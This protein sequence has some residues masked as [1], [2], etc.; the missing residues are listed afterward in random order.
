MSNNKF[1]NDYFYENYRLA[2]FYDELY[3]DI[4]DIPFWLRYINTNEDVLEIAC[5]TGRLT[6]PL[7]EKMQKGIIYA[8]DY[9]SEMLEKLNEKIAYSDH[10]DKIF[11]ILGDMRNFDLGKKF[12]T[13]I[14][15]ANSLNHIEKNEDLIK[16]FENF[17][18]HL[19]DDGKILFDV[20]NPKFEFLQ[21]DFN[22][23]YD[24]MVIKKGN[25]YFSMEE[26]N[27][28]EHKTQINSVS[29]FYNYC[30]ANGVKTYGHSEYR[31]DIKV[32]L[33]FPQEMDA[34]IKFLGL[35]IDGKFDN[36]NGDNFT[37]KTSEQIYIVSKADM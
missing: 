20:L 33:F 2:E 3:G 22:K 31:M 37:G 26:S 23:R 35:K 8:L 7:S 6:I 9:S 29:Y 14:I 13:I 15:S 5:G 12:K 17:K 4:S 27:R 21:R 16:V 36:F 19:D 30:D 25:L 10:K 32:R 24:F 11:P 1:K 18:N 28:Y 34:Y